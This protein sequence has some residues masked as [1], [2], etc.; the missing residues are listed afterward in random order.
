LFLG[1][2][3]ARGERT[4][5]SGS[6]FYPFWFFFF[7]CEIRSF[8]SQLDPLL[9]MLCEDSKL[10]WLGLRFSP[11]LKCKRK[12]TL[13]LELLN[14]INQTVISKTYS[15]SCASASN[16]EDADDQNVSGIRIPIVVRFWT[17]CGLNRFCV[18]N[19]SNGYQM[20]MMRYLFLHSVHTLYT[21]KLSLQ[22]PWLSA[23]Y[24]TNKM[25]ETN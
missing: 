22:L 1:R 14:G 10:P 18:W 2:G 25:L 16:W 23:L 8:K 7:C 20:A 5:S 6:I 21:A 13:I 15:S 11:E 17:C 3:F 19:L 4:K 24:E 9:L 12:E